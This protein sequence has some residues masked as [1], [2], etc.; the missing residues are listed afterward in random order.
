MWAYYFSALCIPNTHTQAH[1]HVSHL[2]SSDQVLCWPP[3]PQLSSLGVN[4]ESQGSRWSQLLTSS[5]SYFHAKTKGLHIFK[6]ENI[7]S[8][9]HLV[10]RNSQ[11]RVGKSFKDCTVQTT[12]LTSEKQRER[13]K[14]QGEDA[15]RL[16]FP[17][18]IHSHGS[19][20]TCT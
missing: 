5:F 13:E 11:I 14:A 16:S 9:H 8:Q 18:Y 2:S 20:L 3:A 19:L 4:S 7:V 12:F 1:T 15:L 10:G 6:R 17:M